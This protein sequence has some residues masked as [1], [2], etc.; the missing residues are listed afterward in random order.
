MKTGVL[1]KFHTVSFVFIHVFFNTV[2]YLVFNEHGACIHSISG[3]LILVR[4][5][6]PKNFQN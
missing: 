1:F 3:F 2:M 5:H 6:F 4:G